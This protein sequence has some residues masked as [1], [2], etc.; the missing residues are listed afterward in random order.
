[1][2]KNNIVHRLAN[3]WLGPKAEVESAIRPL[4]WG[5]ISDPLTSIKEGEI[6]SI[7]TAEL[8]HATTN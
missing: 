5:E 1:M 2:N 8:K 3:L 7:I 4:C 6:D